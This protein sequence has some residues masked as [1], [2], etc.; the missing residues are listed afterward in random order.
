MSGVR[1]RLAAL[2]SAFTASIVWSAVLKYANDWSPNLASMITYNLLTAIFPLLLFIL[3][4]AGII[5]GHFGAADVNR[6]ADTLSDVFPASG[7]DMKA[8]MQ[9]LITTTG[10][11]AVVSFVGLLWLGSNLFVNIEN[12]F[13]I[14]FRVRGRDIIP[15][16]LVACAMV[17]ILAVLLPISLAAA[18]LVVA[19]TDAVRAVL[20]GALKTLLTFAGPFTSFV[21]LWALFLVIYVVVPNI[22]VRL[23]YAMLGA[24]IAAILFTLLELLYPLYLAVFLKGNSRYGVAAAAAL[25]TVIWL[26]FFA[27]ITVIGAQ[28][29]SLVMGLRPTPYDVSRSFEETYQAYVASG[30]APQATVLEKTETPKTPKDANRTATAE[31]LAT[32]RTGALNSSATGSTATHPETPKRRSGKSTQRRRQAS[33][34]HRGR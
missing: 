27:L 11:L 10:P 14:I 28:V 5:L 25:G 17:V 20:P 1:R 2:W 7:V 18:G 4:V 33:R 16:R 21:V 6:F 9:N 3:S 29:N 22:K 15:Q 8:L 30:S 26:W 31:N 12:A 23:R 24:L 13:S 19:G 32:A 34:G